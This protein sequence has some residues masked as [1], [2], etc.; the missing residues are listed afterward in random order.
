M[1]VVAGSRHQRHWLVLPVDQIRRLPVTPAFVAVIAAQRVP[2][3]EQVVNPVMLNKAVGIVE[4]PDA[5]G[6]VPRRSVRIAQ[7]LGHAA[8]HRLNGLFHQV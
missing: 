1:A 2:L 6:Q 5:G 7:R 3:I 4:Q 8:H